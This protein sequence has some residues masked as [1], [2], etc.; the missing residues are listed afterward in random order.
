[1]YLLDTNIISFWMRGD[2]QLIEK[3]KSCSPAILSLS[4]ITLADIYYGIEKSPF[5]KRERRLKIEHIKSQ[6]EIF[7][8][9]ERAAQKYGPLRA[10]LEKKGRPISERDLQ[11]AAIALANKL[12]VVTYNSKEFGRIAKLKVEDWC[13]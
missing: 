3:I 10:E 4:T 7:P 1:M 12:C 6:L 2:L 13:R 11:I 5:N 9:N 8:F